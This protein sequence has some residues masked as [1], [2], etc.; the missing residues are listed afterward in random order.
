MVFWL[1]FVVICGNNLT[2]HHCLVSRLMATTVI[3]RYVT[4]EE[5]EHTSKYFF[6]VNPIKS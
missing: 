4:K 1:I 5:D 6:L 3:K 2:S